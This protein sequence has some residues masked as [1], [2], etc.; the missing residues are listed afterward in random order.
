MPASITLELVIPPELGERDE[1]LDELRMRVAAAEAEFAAKRRRSGKRVLGRRRV[2]AQDPF[3]S[4]KQPTKFERSRNPKFAARNKWS[5]LE[6]LQ[7]NADFIDA[8]RK[9]RRAML[10]GT[11]IPFPFGTF[12]L[13]RHTRVAIVEPQLA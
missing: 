7:R 9:A 5:L 2:L 8:Y 12:W 3:S 11:P 10:T 6:A 13:R 1:I 4:P